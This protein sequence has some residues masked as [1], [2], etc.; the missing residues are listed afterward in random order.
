MMQE[1]IF[2]FV[3]VSIVSCL[4]AGMAGCMGGTGLPEEFSVSTSATEKTPAAPQSGAARFVN[5]K[6]ALFRVAEEGEAP[7]TDD[8]A[9]RGPYGGLLDGGLLERPPASAQIFVVEFGDQGQATRVTENKYFLADIYGD[10]IGVGPQWRP[11]TLPFVRFR[12]APYAVEVND[13]FGLA[14][15]VRVELLSMY[16]GRAVLYAWGTG[17]DER[18]DGQFGYLLDFEGGIGDVL[19]NTTG[20]QYPFFATRVEE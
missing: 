16:V 15:N 19:L 17:D 20:D 2:R 18:L 1:S 6:W 14:V 8:A 10:T 5:S 9:P 12:S 11:T 3:R 13:R 4:A 7:P